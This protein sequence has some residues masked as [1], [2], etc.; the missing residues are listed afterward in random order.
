MTPVD[1]HIHWFPNSFYE[2]YSKRTEIPRTERN[3]NRWHYV[4]GN[5]S[6]DMWPEWFD[7]DM[8]WETVAKTGLDMAVITSMGVHS[9]FDGLPAAEAREAARIINEEWSAAQRRYPGKFFGIAGV[10]LQ[11]T[12]MAIEELDHAIGTLDLRGVSIPG[13]IDGEGLDSPRLE[14]FW[15][16]VEQLGI[17]MFLHPTDGVYRDIMDGYNGG[18]YSSIGRMVDS[19]TAVLRLILSGVLD[20]HPDL[21]IVHFHCGGILPYASG[22]LDKNI[23]VSTLAAKPSEYVKRMWV[24]TA[25]PHA[26]TIEMAI[27]YY[28]RDRVFYGSDNPCWNPTAAL[29]ACNELGL[30]EEERTALFDTNVRDLVDMRAPVAV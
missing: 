16:H 24:D 4:N 5:R 22:R 8:Q 20:R 15:A 28:G 25:M 6:V 11:D 26:L 27:K 30:S 3:G 2:F 14:D 13:N 29:E 10:P 9:D 23:R 17:P 12:A 7:L 18:I 19:S 21:K 1:S